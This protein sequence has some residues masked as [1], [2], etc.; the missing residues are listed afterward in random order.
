MLNFA[1]YIGDKAWNLRKKFCQPVFNEKQY[2]LVHVVRKFLFKAREN[3]YTSVLSLRKNA[4][5]RP[6]SARRVG[7]GRPITESASSASIAARW[8]ARQTLTV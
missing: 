6:D 4:R 7:G 3:E 5:H 1:A 8:R 2:A